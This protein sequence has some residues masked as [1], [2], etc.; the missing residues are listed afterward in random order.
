MN[1]TTD[2]NAE[3]ISCSQFRPSRSFKFFKRSFGGK[4]LQ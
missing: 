2:L 4:G 3:D 1:S